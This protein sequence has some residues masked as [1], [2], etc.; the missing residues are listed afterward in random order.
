MLKKKKRLKSVSVY[1]SKPSN[2]FSERR[3]RNQRSFNNFTGTL[4]T[5]VSV[6]TSR[7]HVTAT[8]EKWVFYPSS[9]GICSDVKYAFLIFFLVFQ[10]HERPT[11]KYTIPLV[12]CCVVRIVFHIQ[13]MSKLMYTTCTPVDQKILEVL[14]WQHGGALRPCC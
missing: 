1:H 7:A 8:Q 6:K 13:Y 12:K 4:K 11:N 3:L 9:K 2:T 5:S 14:H 10:W